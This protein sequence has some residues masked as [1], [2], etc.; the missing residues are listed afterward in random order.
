MIIYTAIEILCDYTT[1]IIQTEKFRLSGIQN[2]INDNLK[3]FNIKKL[4]DKIKIDNEYDFYIEIYGKMLKS[5][6]NPKIEKYFFE[7]YESVKA[8]KNKLSHSEISMHYSK[9]ISYCIIKINSGIYSNPLFNALSRL[10]G[11]LL[12][13]RYYDTNKTGKMQNSLFRDIMLH[14]YN[15]KD[16]ESLRK[17]INKY[18][19]AT[20]LGERM[21]I[22]RYTYYYFLR[23]DFDKSLGNLNTLPDN[24]YIYKYDLYN[25]KLKIFYELNEFQPAEY[26]LKSFSEF[27]RKNA[28]LPVSRNKSHKNF[29]YYY[30]K[31]LRIKDYNNYSDAGYL[32]SKLGRSISITQK[33]WLME[34]AKE[35]CYSS[36][37]S[38]RQTG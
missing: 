1:L 4:Y 30:H 2:T 23:G 5:Y 13:Y 37:Q 22:F 28:Y 19:K 38:L 8:H 10:Y 6:S 12:N 16:A 36:K 31:L 17:F 7:Y 14:Y 24:N 9:L 18:N 35:L 34:K 15:T 25:L 11:E 27:L 20:T 21:L 32:Y 3:W 29:I 33:T 26:V